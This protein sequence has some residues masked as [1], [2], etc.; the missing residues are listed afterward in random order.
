[1]IGEKIFGVIE[2]H[3]GVVTRENAHFIVDPVG[4]QGVLRHQ[5]DT[6]VAIKV[7][8][9]GLLKIVAPRQNIPVAKRVQVVGAHLF[10]KGNEKLLV[11]LVGMRNKDTVIFLF[12]LL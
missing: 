8:L 5:N 1:M 9:D 3:S 12:G 10:Q 7:A 6:C 2:K 4:L 11:V